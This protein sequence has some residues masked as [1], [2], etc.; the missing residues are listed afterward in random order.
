[1]KIGISIFCCVVF[2][3]AFSSSAIA[4]FCQG[5]H[6]EKCI[7]ANWHAWEEHHEHIKECVDRL[8]AAG[9]KHPVDDCAVEHFCGAHSAGHAACEKAALDYFHKHPQKHDEVS[10]WLT[11]QGH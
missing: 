11:N 7:E 6:P 2:V 9:D 1:M 3:F 10:G 8:S 5:D 4:G